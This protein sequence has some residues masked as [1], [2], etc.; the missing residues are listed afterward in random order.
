MPDPASGMEMDKEFVQLVT[1]IWGGGFDC[2]W[3]SR[4]KG[5]ADDSNVDA[6]KALYEELHRWHLDAVARAVREAF[7]EGYHVAV[8]P[9][10]TEKQLRRAGV[11]A[12][13]HEAAA[14]EYFWN[15][16]YVKASVTDA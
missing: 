3:D 2:G 14:E 12:E 8:D 16:S 7:R 11:K 13:A 6:V 4:S 10:W 15:A 1:A 5:K 9:A